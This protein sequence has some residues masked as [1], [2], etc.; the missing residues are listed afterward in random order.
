MFFRDTISVF[1]QTLQKNAELP[2]VA[3]GGAHLP[4]ELHRLTEGFLTQR[5]FRKAICSW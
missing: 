4:L 5:L 2:N 3:V 1:G